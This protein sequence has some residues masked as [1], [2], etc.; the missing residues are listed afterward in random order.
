MLNSTQERY[1]SDHTSSKQLCSVVAHSQL[2]YLPPSILL[3]HTHSLRTHPTHQQLTFILFLRTHWPCASVLIIHIPLHALYSF[4]L[5]NKE[6]I[7]ED[8]NG[9]MPGGSDDEVGPPAHKKQQ[10]NNSNRAVSRELQLAQRAQ[11]AQERRARKKKQKQAE[12]LMQQKKEVNSIFC[13][14]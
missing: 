7:E 8:D 10:Y 14:L 1:A 2:T 6:E 4:S 13:C 3:R 5:N 9:D 11:T 12:A